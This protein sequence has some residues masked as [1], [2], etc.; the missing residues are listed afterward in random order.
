MTKGID[1]DGKADLREIAIAQLDHA[2]K[3]RF[4]FAI[5]GEIIV[6]DEKPLDALGIILAHGAFEI[7]GR[8]KAALASLHIDNGAE[9]ALIW[10]A[11]AEIEAR[12]RPRGAP[13]VLS[14]QER[15]RFSLQVG[16]FVHVVVEQ[17]ELSVPGV[18]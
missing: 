13:D 11:A 5:A 2:I 16:E 10:T 3:Q 15:Q 14:R 4:P 18:A 8:A 7:V 6:G 12:E 17:R 1:L 9:R